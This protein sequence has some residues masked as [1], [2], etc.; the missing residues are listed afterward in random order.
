MYNCEIKYASIQY[1]GA[2][3]QGNIQREIGANCSRLH[4]HLHMHSQ[5]SYVY[6]LKHDFMQIYLLSEKKRKS[7]FSVLLNRSQE[8]K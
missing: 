6:E 3:S 4:T 5:A 8:K 2:N 7:L 1:I